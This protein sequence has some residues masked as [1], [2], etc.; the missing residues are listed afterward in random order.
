MPTTRRTRT[1]RVTKGE[2]MKFT[3]QIKAKAEELDLASKLDDLGSKAKKGLAD[4]KSKAGSVA[5]EQKG[6]IEELL[7]K[8]GDAIDG[9]TDGKY[10]D[11]VA[12][13]KSKAGA[14]VDKVAGHRPDTNPTSEE[15][16]APESTPTT[17]QMPGPDEGSDEAPGT[18]DPPTLLR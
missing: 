11:K 8:A 18:E 6:K 13:A 7:D 10:A 2:Q 17:D 1:E 4:A 9:R 12:T 5:H 3:D 15:P 16:A 14:L